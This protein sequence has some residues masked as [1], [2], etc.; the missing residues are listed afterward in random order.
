MNDDSPSDALAGLRVLIVEDEFHVLLL[1]EDFLQDLGC[2]IAGSATSLNEAQKLVGAGG[3]DAAVLDVNLR[4]EKVY[5]VARQLAERGIPFLFSTGYGAQG[6]DEGWRNS[7]TL[8]KPFAK[9]DLAGLLG[10]V[11]REARRVA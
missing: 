7:P 11:L 5:P 3:F 1:L 10:R 4:G 8:Q 9:H 6:L 2:E